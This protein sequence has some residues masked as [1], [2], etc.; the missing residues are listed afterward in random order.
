MPD[1]T[2]ARSCVT[3]NPTRIP[4]S[5]PEEALHRVTTDTEPADRVL[6]EVADR[7]DTLHPHLPM[8]KDA[9]RLLAHRAADPDHTGRSCTR[10]AADRARALAP[11]IKPG[12]TRARYAEQLRDRVRGGAR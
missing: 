8:S 6:L 2:G 4:R 10:R 11:E 5:Q 12:T 7:L 1:L 9:L 3:S